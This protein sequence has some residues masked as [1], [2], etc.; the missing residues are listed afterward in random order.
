MASRDLTFRF[1]GKDQV[2]PVFRKVGKE[3][4]GL[5]S[6]VSRTGKM[7]GSA[8]GLGAV[9]GI[10]AVGGAL[11]KGA[12]DAVDF[13]NITKQTGAVL[14]STGGAAGVTAK[15]VLDLGNAIE[16]YSAFGNDAVQAGENLLLTFTNIQNKAGKGNDI[17]DQSVKVMADLSQALGQDTKTSAIQLGK[18]LNDPIRGVTALQRVG[19]SFT[20]D[21][22]KQI[23]TLQDSGNVMG[24]QKL[25]L[26]EL[27]KEF[28]GSAKAA[29]QTFGG[30][31]SRLKN[32]FGD[33]NRDLMAKLLPSLT[34][35]VG[36]LATDAV[37]ALMKL[38]HW[39]KQNKD[40]LVPLLAVVGTAVGTY[41]AITAVTKAWK[42]AQLALNFALE[43]NPIGLVVASLAA[44]G[45]GLVIAYKKSETFRKIVNGAFGAVKT[46]A[47]DAFDWI[48]T[49][50]PYLLGA[51][52]GPFGLA[53]VAIGKH[54]DSIKNAFVTAIN[55]VIGKANA[56]IGLFNKI[57]GLPNV[58][59]I[60]TLGTINN[61]SSSSAGNLG[62]RGAKALASGGIVTGPTLAMIGEGRH[63]EAVIPLPDNWRTAGTGGDVHL[64]LDGP[65]YADSEGIK[66]LAR[67]L[68]PALRQ[69]MIRTRSRNGAFVTV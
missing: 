52:A 4:D 25:I 1:L 68:G 69:E 12:K 64:H 60:P 36:F 56:A 53:A 48:K 8:F 6:K 65:V 21:Q 42:G 22:R 55:W 33:M 23:K 34:K 13:Q 62:T 61:S 16:G 51:L 18:A 31:L 66:R 30:Q 2:S 29:G 11:A 17:F 26:A 10:V 50:W 15:H 46:V 20:D 7:L 45:V 14:H 47:V 32:Q 58:P 3:A 35:F 43:A 67:D 57:P 49:N 41:K 44:L 9:G 37:P 40:W 27:S 54:L 24:A 5:G 63:D 38:G 39:I 28:G 59:K 19:V